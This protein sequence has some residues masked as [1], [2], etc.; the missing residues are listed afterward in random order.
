[1]AHRIAVVVLDRFAPLDL[2]TPGQVFRTAESPAGRAALRGGD[3]LAR[4]RARALLGRLHVLPDHGLGV[5]DSADTV[6]VP[7]IHGGP[8]AD[9]TARSTAELREALQGR[10]P[11]DVDL[12][13][14]VRAGRRRP[15]R[16]P[17]RH[18]ALARGRPVPRAVPAVELDPDVLFIDDG[19]VL[20]SAGVAAG[21]RPVPARDP[22]RPRQRG[23]QPGGP[24]LRRAALAGRRPGPVHRAARA[25]A[26]AG[27]DRP[28]P[29]PG[30]SSQ[31]GRAARPGRR[32]PRTRA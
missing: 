29:A 14:R 11:G 27:T 1:M 2:G 23:G 5:L 3:L 24:P 18:H 9:A 19:D 15:A 8:R 12:H 31:P 26:A 7:G 17:A 16:R 28:P 30:C 22:A 20:T 10:P 25:G 4:R 6:L 21:H 13:G 32:W